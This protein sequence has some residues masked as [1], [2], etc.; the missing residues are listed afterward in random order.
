[1]SSTNGENSQSDK[2]LIIKASHQKNKLHAQASCPEGITISLPNMYS[3][4]RNNPKNTNPSKKRG[5]GEGK[6][7]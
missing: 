7:I 1:M 3:F 5:G 6:V 2:R 4:Q